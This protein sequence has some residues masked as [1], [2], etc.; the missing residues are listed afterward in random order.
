MQ[1]AINDWLIKHKVHQLH[2]RQ[3]QTITPIRNVRVPQCQTR[4]SE[5]PSLLSHLV[6]LKVRHGLPTVGDNLTTLTRL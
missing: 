2:R 1:K 5:V 6:C 4:N 3:S